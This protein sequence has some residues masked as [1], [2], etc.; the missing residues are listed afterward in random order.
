M[1]KWE[2]KKMD[3]YEID[4]FIPDPPQPTNDEILSQTIAQ[5][6]LENADLKAQLQTLAQTIATMQLGGV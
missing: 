2:T 4:V 1:P 5:L 3:G 6:I